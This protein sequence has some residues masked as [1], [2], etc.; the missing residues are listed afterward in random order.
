MHPIQLITKPRQ[1]V[2]IS[3]PFVRFWSSSVG[4]FACSMDSGRDRVVCQSESGRRR[5]HGPGC[6]HS[7]ATGRGGGR[8]LGGSE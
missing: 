8:G 6:S 3:V 7:D 5:E 4:L 2:G 1:S